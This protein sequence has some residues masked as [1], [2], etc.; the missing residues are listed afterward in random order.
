MHLLLSSTA[1]A[2]AASAAAS[3]VAYVFCELVSDKRWATIGSQPIYTHFIE[4]WYI[5]IENQRTEKKKV[6]EKKWK[7]AKADP[8]QNQRNTYIL[9]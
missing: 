2:A 7:S 1:P 9:R 8:S 6:V 3:A 4:S 5:E